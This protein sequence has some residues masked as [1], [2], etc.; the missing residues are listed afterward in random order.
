M[1][2][3]RE[4]SDS[5]KK[6]AEDFVLRG[7]RRDDSHGELL[8]FEGL[9]SDLS[10]RFVN[11]PPDQV[12]SE[13]EC[14]LKR[15]LEFF[16]VER[17][18]LIGLSSDRK[19]VHVTHIA[20]VEGIETVS[21]DIDLSKLF[22][23][24]Y[25]KLMEGHRVCFFKIDDLPEEAL[26]DR[27]SYS[28]MG[29]VSDLTIPLFYSGSISAIIAL[30][31]LRRHRSWPEEYIP[32]LQLLG[33]IF[34]NALERKNADQVLRES[35]AR[36][37]LAADSA[38]AML[39]EIDVGSGHLWTTETAREFFGFAPDDDL[40][41]ETF[42]S[43]V[44][45]E[46]RDRLRRTVEQSISSGKDSSAEYRVVRPGGSIR[47]IL[48]RG[49]PYSA[50]EG[51]SARLMGVSIDITKRI[52]AEDEIR[53]AYEEISSLKDRLEAE[54]IY[55]KT[56]IETFQHG[57]TIIG[58]SDSMK[59]LLYRISQVAPQD[60]TVL[61]V[62][63]TGTGKGLVARAVHE[64][65]LRK[66]RPM[67]HVNCASLPGN[68]IESELFGREKGAFTGAQARQIGRFQL[69]DKGTIFLDEIAE[70]PVE[71]QAKLLRVI[72]S[73][74]F[75]RLGDPHTIKVDVRIISSTNRDIHE[76][77]LKGKFRQDLF[78][79]LN[80]FPITVPSLRERKDD[81]PLIVE[82]LIMRLNKRLGRGISSVPNEVMRAL[83]S[84]SWP[85]NVR[86][87][88]NVIERAVIMN[89]GPT[90]R[91]AEQLV[92]VSPPG[93]EV[94]AA[95]FLTNLQREHIQ[96]TLEEL[97]WKIEGPKGAANVLGLKP[98]TLRSRMKKLN[99]RRP[100]IS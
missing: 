87:L 89:S 16:Q 98:A 23:W 28:A 67:I 5:G 4:N 61:I 33:E 11:I 18:G 2:L 43:V 82:A 24:S 38:G 44:H 75:E 36:L 92:A 26:Q 96:K 90:L 29:I 49:R 88:E 10:A 52:E 81:I 3:S 78:Y 48:S 70:L 94:A 54:N 69:A 35:E 17:C 15:M 100:D 63:E 12:D 20:Y 46:D 1:T 47:W 74:E 21:G 65:S 37:S 86:E 42:L 14:A 22:P 53:K 73:G 25:E 79:R 41:I 55:L 27:A 39:W 66:D 93:A 72:E 6:D 62:G 76:E 58:R 77:I 56:E 85:G 83:Q 97:N 13:I 80:V 45:Y 40:S 34:I 32:R 95:S 60:S 8:R 31:S 64:G 99:I 51:E 71:L 9:I 68:L 57:E 59:Y 30:N 19:R 50:S 84:Y 91:L 7:R